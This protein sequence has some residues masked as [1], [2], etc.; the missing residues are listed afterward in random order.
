M[1]P[2][3]IIIRPVVSEKSYALMS[4]G[5]YTF[6]VHDRAHKTQIA[7]AV[8]EIFGVQ[9]SLGEDLEGQL[10]AEAPRPARGQD[11]LLEEGDRA[12]RPRSSASSCS[13]ARRSRA[14]R[15]DGQPQ[16]QADQPRAPLRHLPDPRGADRRRARE[17]PVEGQATLQR[18]E[19]Q[20]PHHLAP[21]RRRGQAPLP[22]DRLQAG[23]GRRARQG[24]LDRV[25]PEPQRLH[26]AHQLR[27]RPQ[28]LH[29]RAA[30]PAGRRRGDVRARR[31]TSRS[32]TRCRWAGS[33]PA[34]WSTTSR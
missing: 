27:R 28:E 3:Q 17:E 26:R 34:P 32:A 14:R 13:R 8:E 11:P 24:R 23:Q 18:A 2:R 6:R 16:D 10:E 7:Q 9:R 31:P 22:P 12:A 1:D 21:P 19:R 4:D 15:T 33:R 30:G 25:R 5:K 29:P 20:R